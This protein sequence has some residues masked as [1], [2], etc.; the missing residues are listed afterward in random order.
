VKFG[1]QTL[2]TKFHALQPAGCVV[3]GPDRTGPDPLAQRWLTYPN[4]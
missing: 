2:I 4:M 3:T 1:R